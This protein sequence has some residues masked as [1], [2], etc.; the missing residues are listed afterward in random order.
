MK[1]VRI[2]IVGF[3]KVIQAFL[4]LL[5]EKQEYLMTRHHLDLKVVAICDST[6][7]MLNY[8]GFDPEEL[9]AMKLSKKASG[10]SMAGSPASEIQFLIDSYVQTDVNTVVEALPPRRDSGEPALSYLLGFL[11]KKV[12]GVPVDKS[13]LVFGYP[14]LLAT[15]R[16]SKVALKFS[17]ATAA[18]LPTTDTA[19]FGLAGADLYGFEGI[20]NGTTNFLLTEMI[21]NRSSVVD[22]LELAVEMK[23]CEPDPSF[24]IDGWDTAFKTLI[25]TKAFLDPYQDLRDVEVQGV[26]GLTYADL[27]S[28]LASGNTV[29]LL[30]KASYEDERLRLRVTPSIITPDHP[31]FFV[32]GTGKAITFYTDTLGKLTMIGGASGLRETAATILKDIINIH[33]DWGAS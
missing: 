24:D 19:A 21:K 25:L 12:A 30:G 16:K 26:R 8:E 33:R 15:A 18:A 10:D 3:G 7:Y 13:P 14:Q 28:V 29:K 6:E 23:I 32:D 4:E 17:G 5:P 31:F 27:E 22:E 11:A 20:L 9:L 1:S 2:G